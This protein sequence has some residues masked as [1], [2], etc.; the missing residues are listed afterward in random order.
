MILFP[1][2]SYR[3]PGALFAALPPSAMFV[4]LATS[5]CADTP[6]KDEQEAAKQHVCLPRSPAS[7]SSCASIP[8][9]PGC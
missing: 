6:S 8:A 3:A 1:A 9:K 7:A 5:G 2:L 4:A